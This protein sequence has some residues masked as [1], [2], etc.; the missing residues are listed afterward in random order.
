MVLQ[1]AVL[2]AEM[3][4]AEPAIPHDAL[5]DLLTLLVRAADL[6]GRHAAAHRHDEV[7]CG[8]GLD[9]VGGEGRVGG[10]QVFAGVDK[11]EGCCWEGGAEGEEGLDVREGDVDGDGE[12]DDWGVGVS[13][14]L[15]WSWK[16][17]REEVGLLSPLRFLMK[18]CI[19]SEGSGEAE[20]ERERDTMLLV[21][22]SGE[23]ELLVVVGW[24]C[25]GFVGVVADVCWACLWDR[26]FEL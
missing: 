26:E 25:G 19:V 14:W 2:P 18:I 12:R 20:L 10:G 7:E 21:G 17:G 5:R 22:E 6:L 3:P 15:L 4:I 23:R 11:V 13:A 16:G 24:F 9:A 8:F 1:E